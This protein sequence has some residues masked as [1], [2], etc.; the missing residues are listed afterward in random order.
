MRA[1]GVSEWLLFVLKWHYLGGQKCEAVTYSLFRFLFFKQDSL[2]DFF[3]SYN[4]AAITI[5]CKPVFVSC[6][7]ICKAKLRRSS[8]LSL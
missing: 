3:L 2:L 4:C 1:S 8:H 7:F 6:N 5:A